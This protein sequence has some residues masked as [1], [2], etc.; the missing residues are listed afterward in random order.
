MPS[1]NPQ[2]KPEDAQADAENNSGG[3]TAPAPKPKEIGGR[4]NG[5]EP[6]RYGDWEMNGRCVDF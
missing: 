2:P 4:K 6:T 1:N 5:L 3:G